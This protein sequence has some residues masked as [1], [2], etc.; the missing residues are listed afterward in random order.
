MLASRDGHTNIIQL[1]LEHCADI[2]SQDKVSSSAKIVCECFPYCCA[3]VR[4]AV[5][6]LQYYVVVQLKLTHC[7]L[8]ATIVAIWPN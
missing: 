4:H 3:P 8:M 5:Q 2:N 7:P 6:L 1:L